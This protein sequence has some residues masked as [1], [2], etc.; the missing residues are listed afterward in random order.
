MTARRFD[1]FWVDREVAALD[2]LAA[3]PTDVLAAHV[4][5]HGLCLYELLI[6]DPPDPPADEDPDRWFAE[7]LCAGCPVRC[8]CLEVELRDFGS[9]TLGV[10]GALRDQD[11]QD[12]IASWEAHPQRHRDATLVPEGSEAN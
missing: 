12:L 4:D 6:G 8:E 5:R 9:W 11:R 2:H 3:I 1:G 10:W 7:M